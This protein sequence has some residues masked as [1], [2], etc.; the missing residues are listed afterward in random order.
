VTADLPFQWF[1]GAPLSVTPENL[2]LHIDL[3]N[4]HRPLQGKDVP[5]AELG[6]MSGGPVFRL[7]P[8][9]PIERM[10]LVAF[11]YESQPSLSLVYARPSHYITED[12]FISEETAA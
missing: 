6:G 11:I 8:A 4:F 1:A 7:I 12:G 9:P 2:K 5:N 10:E 3:E